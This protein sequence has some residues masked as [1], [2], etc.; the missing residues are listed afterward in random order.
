M[1][2]ALMNCMMELGLAVRTNFVIKVP[3]PQDTGS[4]D[5]GPRKTTALCLWARDSCHGEEGNVI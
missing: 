4:Y 3:F 2:P 5:R 1:A